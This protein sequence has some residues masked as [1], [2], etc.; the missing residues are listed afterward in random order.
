MALLQLAACTGAGLEA[1]GLCP[2][3]EGLAS[4][5][6]QST[7]KVVGGMTTLSTRALFRKGYLCLVHPS[8]G[9]S[10]WLLSEG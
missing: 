5:A 1:A 7:L 2:G 9:H 8:L 10:E 6:S 4:P 3:P